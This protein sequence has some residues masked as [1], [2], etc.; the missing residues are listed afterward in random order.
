MFWLV[1]FA[2]FLIRNFTHLSF[3]G[4]SLK[5]EKA[6]FWKHWRILHLGSPHQRWMWLERKMIGIVG[7]ITNCSVLEQG[8]L[9]SVPA[10]RRARSQARYRYSK[11]YS[12]KTREFFVRIYFLSEQWRIQQK[13]SPE[14]FTKPVLQEYVVIFCSCRPNPTSVK[15]TLFPREMRRYGRDPFIPSLLCWID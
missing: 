3:T 4:W 14:G 13:G 6:K 9:Q 2:P 10:W 7:S 12:H 11:C 15:K 5:T 8:S 1:G